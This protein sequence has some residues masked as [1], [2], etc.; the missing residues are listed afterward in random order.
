MT[1]AST[2]IGNV[3]GDTMRA[4]AYLFDYAMPLMAVTI[5]RLIPDH[6]RGTL[7]GGPSASLNA[8]QQMRE[9]VGGGWAIIKIAA[10]NHPDRPP[11]P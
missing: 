1:R 10:S 6:T 2:R 7:F 9:Q 3:M 8:I 11:L 4:S 5:Y